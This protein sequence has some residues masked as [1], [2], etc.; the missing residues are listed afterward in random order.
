MSN[1]LS[2]G[3]VDVTAMTTRL[4]NITAAISG[5]PKPSTMAATGMIITSV[6]MS[7]KVSEMAEANSPISSALRGCP[8]LVSPWPSKTV[9]MEAPVP[10]MEIRMAGTLPP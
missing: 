9:A 6:K 4:R 5:G 3:P 7:L 1:P 10:G 2:T 8:F